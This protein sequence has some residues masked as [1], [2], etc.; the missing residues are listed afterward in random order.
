MKTCT[1]QTPLFAEDIQKLEAGNKVLISGTIFTGR[2]SLHQYLTSEYRQLEFNLQGAVIYHCGPIVVAGQHDT[3]NLIAAGPTTSGRTEAY[4]PDI[5]RDYGVAAF[6]GKG[7]L[8][9]KSLD[10]FKQHKAVYLS[11]VGGCAQV[12]ANAVTK[13]KNVYFL[14]EFGSPEAVWELE[15]KNFPAI[16]T[17]GCT[18]C[19]YACLSSYRF[20]YQI[21]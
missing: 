13:V 15:V 3:W 16:V 4:V 11:A 18:L 6:I 8:G 21:P 5:V 1:L 14:E 19:K 9:P 12:L 10:A 20:L 17:I 2:D 7:G